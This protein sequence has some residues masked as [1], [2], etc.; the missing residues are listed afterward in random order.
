MAP[1]GIEPAC[2]PMRDREARVFTTRPSQING[3]GKVP[4]QEGFERMGV[5]GR[6]R[7][8]HGLGFCSKSR[9]LKSST[10]TTRLSWVL[11][12]ANTAEKSRKDGS[13]RS[14]DLF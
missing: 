3:P 7:L 5:R 14:E 2:F 11:E 8:S 12:S 4:P 10:K 6:L 13:Q 1:P 9:R